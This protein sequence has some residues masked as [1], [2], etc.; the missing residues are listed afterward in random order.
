MRVEKI[1]GATLYHGDC[2]EIL[3]EISGA[4]C[5]ISDPPYGCTKNDWDY[6]IDLENFWRLAKGAC[7]ENAA[8]CLFC[9]MPFAARLGM[10]NIKEFRYEWVFYKAKIT[11][12]LNAGWSPLRAHESV[13]VYCGRKPFYM[14]QKTLGKPYKKNRGHYS[15]NYGKI[16]DSLT[17]NITG[18]RCPLSIVVIEHD[19]DFSSAKPKFRRHPTQKSVA[20]MA[21]LIKTHSEKG[22]IVLDPFMGSGSTGVA[23][24]RNGRNFIGIER[25]K[26][27]FDVA[28]KRLEAELRE[29]SLV[30]MCDGET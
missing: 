20:E 30:E 28:C 12:F 27:W 13:H 26:R 14:P 25:E 9:Q 8:F 4:D 17:E 23:A 6:K 29:N 15:P 3:P 7:K 22:Q 2:F 24:L 21:Y 18:E 10:S 5:L 19:A 1:G 16:L 11:N